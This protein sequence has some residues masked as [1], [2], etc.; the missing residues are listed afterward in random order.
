MASRTVGLPDKFK[1]RAA[2]P[3]NGP[4][5]HSVSG[6]RLAI[7]EPMTRSSC[8]DIRDSKIPKH[9]SVSM[10][11]VT[12]SLLLAAFNALAKFSDSRS[13]SIAPCEAGRLLG[14]RSHG[15]SRTGKGPDNF[16]RQKSKGS[17]ASAEASHS[18]CQAAKS[19]Y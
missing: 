5:R 9:V 10:N 14:G 18:F 16:F 12:F 7:G 11:I 8:P 3:A 13:V 4:I 17:R 15:K 1:R 2:G 19:L 6:L